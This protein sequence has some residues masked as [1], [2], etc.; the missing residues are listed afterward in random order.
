MTNK[1]LFSLTA[2]TLVLLLVGCDNTPPPPAIS[3]AKDI[4]PIF[5]QHCLECHRPGGEGERSSGL[6]LSSHRGLMRGTRF[7][8]V[9][10]AGNSLSSTLVILVEGRADKSINMPHGNRPP[11]EA[12]QIKQLREWIDQGAANN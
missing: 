12:T 1:H 7:G 11:V 8:P 9:V 2:L 5:E 4:M 10:I 6:D 3:F